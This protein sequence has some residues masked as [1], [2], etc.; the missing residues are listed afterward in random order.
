MLLTTAIWDV[1]N[2]I[3]IFKNYFLADLIKMYIQ[4]FINEIEFQELNLLYPIC[5]IEPSAFQDIYFAML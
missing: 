1:E 5:F 3:I 2:Y 4:H